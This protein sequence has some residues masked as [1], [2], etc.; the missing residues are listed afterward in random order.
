MADSTEWLMKCTQ[1]ELVRSVQGLQEQRE[2]LMKDDEQRYCDERK[3]LVLSRDQV[4]R[5]TTLESQVSD[6]RDDLAGATGLT[7]ADQIMI[8]SAQK[9]L[10][11]EGE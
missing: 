6:A 9:I 5:I 4:A 11:V 3:A 8:D 7:E 2:Q 10:D 1:E